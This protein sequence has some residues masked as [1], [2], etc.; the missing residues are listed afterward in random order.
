MHKLEH[1]VKQ[2]KR[3]SKALVLGPTSMNQLF[4]SLT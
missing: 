2:F 1:K 3:S 4:Q